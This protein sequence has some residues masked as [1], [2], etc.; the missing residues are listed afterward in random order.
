MLGLWPI[1]APG[2]LVDIDARQP[3]RLATGTLDVKWRCL[4]SHVEPAIADALLTNYS[5]L[6]WSTAFVQPL[7]ANLT[8]CLELTLDNLHGADLLPPLGVALATACPYVSD[9]SRPWEPPRS[10]APLRALDFE[11]STLEDVGA[12]GLAPIIRA[13]PSIAAIYAPSNRISDAGARALADALFTPPHAGVKLLDLHGNVIG[14][15]GADGLA[16]ML[17]LQ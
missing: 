5:M 3:E 15:Y 1:V 14:D 9:E 16:R 13:C 11:G 12:A 7:I 4:Q 10:P 6:G 2:V 17:T 8:G